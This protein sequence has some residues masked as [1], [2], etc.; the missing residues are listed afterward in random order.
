MT[1]F[2]CW[3]DKLIYLRFLQE[4]ASLVG[5]DKKNDVFDMIYQFF[6]RTEFS[7]EHFV[8]T[9][10]IT[11][12]RATENTRTCE[13]DFLCASQRKRVELASNRGIDT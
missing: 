11:A 5:L 7:L 9:T 13:F 8:T 12:D 4:K 10:K 3:K 6:I 2:I 1:R